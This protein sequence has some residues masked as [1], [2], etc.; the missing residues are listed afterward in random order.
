MATTILM[1]YEERNLYS[2][3]VWEVKNMTKKPRL[4]VRLVWPAG[5][6]GCVG[7]IAFP[8]KRGPLEALP[9]SWAM[10]CP[11]CSRRVETLLGVGGMEAPN[12]LW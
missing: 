6:P 8:G 10:S 2:V 7:P 12:V 4:E 11:S 3:L 1:R 9:W 5:W